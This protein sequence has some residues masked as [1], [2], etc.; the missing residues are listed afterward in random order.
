MVMKRLFK[1]S[2]SQDRLPATVPEG[3]RVYAIGD[4]HGRLDLLEQ[5]LE[6]INEDDVGRGPCGTDIIFLGDLIDRGPESAG[7][8]ERLRLLA[9]KDRRCR[10]LMGNHEEIFLRAL[11]GDLQSLKLMIRIGG[12][13]TILSYG[14][15]H[16]QYLAWDFD[17]L[18][19]TLNGIVPENHGAFIS[20]FE[21]TIVVGDY[22]FVHA[23]LR[24]NLPIDQQ[25]VSDLRWIRKDFLESK[26]DFGGMVVHGHNVTPE[27]DRQINRIGI[28]T[29]A[30]ASGRLTALC[31]EG[32][33]QW[34][35]VAKG[36]AA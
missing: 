27:I 13:E 16:A 1:L 23:G 14:V 24:P 6:K 28:D 12:K 20:G 18:L 29:G 17:E 5:L 36:Q 9:G 22:I 10:F 4:V 32:A 30:Y 7:V 25:R 31:L 33:A 15:D 35:L 2:R 19:S 34:T 3:R 21:D 26:V 8:V 11:S